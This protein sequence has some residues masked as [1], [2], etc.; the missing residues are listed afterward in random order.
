VTIPLVRVR[1]LDGDGHLDLIVSDFQATSLYV[2]RGNGAGDFEEGI[3]I[4]AGAPVNAFDIGDV[5]GDGFPDLVTAN[6]DHTVSV[7]VNRGPCR[8]ARHRATSH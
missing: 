5:N 4:D 6:N 3:A 2:Y 7:I 1:D 8:P